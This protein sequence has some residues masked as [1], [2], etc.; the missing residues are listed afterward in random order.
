MP[1]VWL[2]TPL[3]VQDETGL[4]YD[5]MAERFNVRLYG[6]YVGAHRLFKEATNPSLVKAYKD[7]ARDVRPLD[8]RI[9]YEKLAGSALQVATR[10]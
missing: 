8:F 5:A 4:D 1:A 10:K 2:Q 3:L 6:E 7:H 9:G